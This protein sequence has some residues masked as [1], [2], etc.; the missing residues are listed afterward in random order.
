MGILIFVWRKKGKGSLGFIFVSQPTSSWLVDT[1]E[2]GIYVEGGC[3][4]VLWIPEGWNGRG[5]RRI[6]GELCQLITTKEKGL[7]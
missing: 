4:G 3:K 2:A 7:A 6:V 1:M 5:W